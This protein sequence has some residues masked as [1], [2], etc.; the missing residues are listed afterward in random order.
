MGQT[1]R[2]RSASTI[3]YPDIAEVRHFTPDPIPLVAKVRTFLP[4]GRSVPKVRPKGQVETPLVHGVTT[5]A[6]P[7]DAELMRMPRHRSGEA[8]LML[9]PWYRPGEAELL[10]PP[11]HRPG[12]VE[13]LL[14]PWHRLG[15]VQQVL[16]EWH[17]H[18]PV[19]L[20]LCSRLGLGRLK[21]S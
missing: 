4:Q 9:P 15:E 2:G 19:M 11:W 14:P 13:L 20:S 18:W 17:R 16:P 12:K 5:V 7:G 1:D 8:G 21:L 10:L 6:R 3:P